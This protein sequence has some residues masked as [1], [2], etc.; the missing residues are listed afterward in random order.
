[1][2]EYNHKSSQTFICYQ[3]IEKEW[4]YYFAKELDKKHSGEVPLAFKFVAKKP[5]TSLQ[6]SSGN[7]GVDLIERAFYKL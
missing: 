2:C 6:F 5:M 7:R 3:Y 1:M 4:S